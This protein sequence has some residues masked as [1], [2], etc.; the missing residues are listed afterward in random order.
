MTEL[1]PPLFIPPDDEGIIEEEVATA[2]L[3]HSP[4]RKRSRNLFE[5]EETSMK[6]PPSQRSEIVRDED[7]YLSDGSCIIL[8]GNTLFNVSSFSDRSSSSLMPACRCTELLFRKIHPP[9]V[10]CFHYRGETSQPKASQT[11]TQSSSLGT[12]SLSSATSCGR[13]MLCEFLCLAIAF[14]LLA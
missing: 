14:Y 10:P 11:T 3:L 2:R 4:P 7:Y 6:A 9:L 13:C 1:D 5:I 8:V 12:P